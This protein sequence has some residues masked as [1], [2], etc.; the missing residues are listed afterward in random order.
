MKPGTH[1]LY[2]SGN[3]LLAYVLWNQEPVFSKN[4][5]PSTSICTMELGTLFQRSEELGTLT[6]MEPGTHP[7]YY[8]GTLY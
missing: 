7:Q 6:T 3:S 2:Y 1:F 5:E 8:L 4:W